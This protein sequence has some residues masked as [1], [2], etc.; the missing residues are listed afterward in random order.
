MTA[1]TRLSRA[2]AVAALGF[3]AASGAQ[4]QASWDIDGCSGGVKNIAGNQAT[5]SSTGFTGCGGNAAAN[6]V[7]MSVK[8]YTSTGATTTFTTANLN[9]QSSNGTGYLG[10]LTGSEI[11]GSSSPHHAIDNVTTGTASNPYEMVLLSFTSA[12][13]LSSIVATWTNAQVGGDADFQ[14]F[15]W[16]GTNAANMA[17][18]P[19]DMPATLGAT[20]NGWTLVTVSDFAA[21][22]T[23]SISDSNYFASSWLISTAFGGSNDAFKLGKVYAANV[24][25]GNNSVVSGACTPNNPNPPGGA[26]PEPASLALFGV[27]AFGAGFARRRARAKAA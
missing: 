9:S 14:L 21:N 20:A 2:L 13:D 22:L 12:V 27:A 1:I 10:V 19:N 25:T 24:C 5:G 8:G 7:T 4:A 15:R 11:P 17:L 3:V 23:Q 26:A 6:G 18:K 16:N